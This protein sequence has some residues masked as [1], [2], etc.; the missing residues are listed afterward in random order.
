MEVTD[1][2]FRS[3]LLQILRS[4]SN[5]TFVAV[6]VE[7][8]GIS[9]RRHGEND[10]SHDIGKPNLQQQYEETKDAA[11]RYQVLQLGITCV[12]DD[13]KRSTFVY[14]LC[15]KY[16]HSRLTKPDMYVA[17]PY[18]FNVTPLFVQG[19]RLDINRDITFS[20]SAIQ[21]LQKN[22]FDVGAVF[23]RGVPYLS[24]EEEESARQKFA[25]RQEN[26]ASIPDIVISESDESALEFFRNARTTIS[27][28]AN[29]KKV[30]TCNFLPLGLAMHPLRASVDLGHIA[31]LR[32]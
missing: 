21:F 11:E 31:G 9:T 19:D 12:E 26:S 20:S 24:R 25:K 22:S 3:Q 30:C 23:T 27:K 28:W 5:A 4:I 6:D 18:N 29:A 14:H 13:R 7:M 16:E 10:R 32:W 2:N 8:S 1:L 17:R 15:R